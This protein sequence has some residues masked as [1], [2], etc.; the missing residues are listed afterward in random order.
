MKNRIYTT[1]GIVCLIGI[2]C[3]IIYFVGNF[4]YFGVYEINEISNNNNNNNNNTNTNIDNVCIYTS[5]NQYNNSSRPVKS[6]KYKDSLHIPH[7][8]F[9]KELNCY[10]I[11][12]AG[13]KLEDIANYDELVEQMN[14]LEN[15]RNKYKDCTIEDIK[16]VGTHYTD[17][18][19]QAAEAIRYN[20]SH[21]DN[22]YNEGYYAG[23]D[24]GYETAKRELENN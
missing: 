3:F 13:N 22:P 19:H 17:N 20:L 11:S 9:D 1:I 23:Y 15:N 21:K 16:L 24:A 14:R 8:I 5:D 12:L 4:I 18:I 10:A 6:M 7:V 2:M